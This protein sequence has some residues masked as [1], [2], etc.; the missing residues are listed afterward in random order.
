MKKLSH[1]QLV[2]VLLFAA[3]RPIPSQSAPS[4]THHS[5]WRIPGR[6]NTVYLLG[7]AHFLKKS[8]YPLP[9]VMENAFSNSAMVVFETDIDK[10]QGLDVQM[11]FM[12]KAQL[13]EGQTL[14]QQLSTN[15]Y[16]AFQEHLK[17][18]GLNEI[19]FQNFQPAL[20]AMTLEVI[21]MQKAGLDPSQGLDQ[22]FFQLADKAGR[23]IV[24]LETVDFQIDLITGFSPEEG[25]LIMKSTLEDIDTI[26]KQLGELLEGWRN[27]DTETLQKLLNHAMADAPAIFKRLVTDRNRQWVPKIEE[28]SRADQSVIVIVGAGHLVGPEGVVELLRKQGLKVVQE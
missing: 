22:H 4:Q 23:K 17:R 6:T 2:L 14:R 24:P 25:E 15:T 13:P 21:A 7:S 11:R 1:W 28:W 27:G 12:K 5:L 26:E 9:P 20:A 10:L 16:A 8:D 18:A 19:M 3:A